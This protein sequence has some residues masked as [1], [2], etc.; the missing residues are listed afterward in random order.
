MINELNERSRE[1]LK[2]VIDSYVETGDP[3]GS[4]LISQ[5]QGINLSSATI[6][7]VMS[8]LEDLGLLY[9]PH[10]SAGRLPTESGLAVFVDSLLEINDLSE[11]EKRTIEQNIN[12]HNNKSVHDILESTTNYLSGL[13]SCASIVFVPKIENTIKQIEFVML[14]PGRAIVIIVSNSGEVENRIISI[15]LEVTASSIT[16]ATNYLNSRIANKTLSQASDQIKNELKNNK[17]QIDEISKKLVEAGIAN[18]SPDDKGGHLFIKGQSNL[19]EDINALEDL[20]K[21]RSLFEALETKETLLKLLKSTVDGEG[22]K[23][24]IGAENNLFNYSG[25]SMVMSSYKNEESHVVGAIGV[26]GPSRLNYGR[27]IPVVN[28]TSQLISKIIK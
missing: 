19:L 10:T 15:P 6:R 1:I 7:G 17:T 12:G 28:Y 11:A 22:M 25:C 23:I 4:K 13:S 14:A 3:V 8:E 16:E 21:I 18:I 2:L 9:S 5:K 24:F 27:I 26:I 20:E